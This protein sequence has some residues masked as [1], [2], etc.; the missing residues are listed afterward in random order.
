MIT[1]TITYNS[2]P[3]A[4]PTLRTKENN[5]VK[6]QVSSHLA[7]HLGHRV[8]Q[9]VLHHHPP[10]RHRRLLSRPQVRAW[11]TDINREVNGSKRI[12][13]YYTIPP[14]GTRCS[15]KG[16]CWRFLDMFGEG[17]QGRVRLQKDD[18]LAFRNI[19]KPIWY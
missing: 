7:P 6:G 5:T 2:P 14:K 8:A 12:Y 4:R 16:S 9:P 17:N 1:L 18:Y 13:H 11:S 19:L 10:D 15:K 3:W